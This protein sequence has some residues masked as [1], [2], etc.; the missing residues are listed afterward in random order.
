[1]KNIDPSI[2]T[3]ILRLKELLNAESYEYCFYDFERETM[4]EKNKMYT[5]IEQMKRDES[6][7]KH[8]CDEI[9]LKLLNYEITNICNIICGK[10]Y[11]YKNRTDIPIQIVNGY[12]YSFTVICKKKYGKEL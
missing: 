5:T 10:T 4:K 11:K 2:L 1:M 12:Y 8:F 3:F 9:N 6:I 7:I